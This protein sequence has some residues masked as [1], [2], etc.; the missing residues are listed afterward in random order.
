MDGLSMR[1]WSIIVRYPKKK[2]GTGD[3]DQLHRLVSRCPNGIVKP[4][5]LEGEMRATHTFSADEAFKSLNERF[6]SENITRSR[7]V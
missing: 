4:E 6:L 1:D 3:A 2:T 5:L 7:R